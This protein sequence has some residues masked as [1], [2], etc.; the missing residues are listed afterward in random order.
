[1]TVG[2]KRLQGQKNEGTECVGGTTGRR[3]NGS[4]TIGGGRRGQRKESRKRTRGRGRRGERSGRK[5]R[6]GRRHL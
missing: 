2:T 5:G 3:Y 4:S 1:M 6:G